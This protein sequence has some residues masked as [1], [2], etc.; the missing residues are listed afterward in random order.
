MAI[1]GT[2]TPGDDN[3][4][5]DASNNLIDALA[6]NDTVNGNGGNDTLIGGLG[7][8]VLLGAVGNDN[9]IG[10]EGNDV[11]GGDN[12]GGTGNDSLSGGAGDD[13]LN[14]GL[15]RDTLVGGAG[16][17]TYAVGS[18]DAIIIEQANQG[19]DIVN[20]SISYTLGANLER[21]TL[22]GTARINGT[23]NALSNSI[24]GNTANNVLSGLAGDDSINGLD[25]N[26]TLTGGIGNDILAGGLGVDR[27]V[28]SGDVNFTLTN[29]RLTGNGTDTLNSIETVFLT[30]GAGNN[31][32]DAS[33]FT[34]N[35]Q[36][37]GGFGDDQLKAGSKGNNLFGGSGNDTLI[38]GAGDD[39]LFGDNQNDLLQGGAG[40]DE[41]K[42]GAG[43]DI[44]NGNEGNDDL[45]GESGNDTINGGTGFDSILFDPTDANF[46]LS[47]KK[48]EVKNASLTETDNLSSIEQAT[49]FGRDS[50]NIMAAS[51]F[52]GMANLFG[53]G[54]N[55]VLTGGSGSDFLA[56][57]DGVDSLNG[58]GDADIKVN[59]ERDT[60]S[61]GSD[62]DFFVLGFNFGFGAIGYSDFGSLDF[63]TITD[64][65]AG[66]GDKFRVGGNS[67]SEYSLVKQSFGGIGSAAIDTQIFRGN[68]LIAVVQDNTDVFIPRD[69]QIFG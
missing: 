36:L 65:S 17:D 46:T 23:G 63:A 41:L 52:S 14:G 2:P 20:S 1:T 53:N 29:T 34:G 26:D 58:F 68:E 64:F 9:L 61:G 31:T 21:L 30:G 12:F 28:E 24:L 54:G 43:N 13:K 55:D 44:L 37:N 33:S 5:G 62:R 27:V 39:G 67:L 51:G 16:S 48:L 3:I 8:D 66:Q 19:N 38:G 42:G 18:A 4:L 60:L 50:G 59:I 15:G 25:G 45:R 35:V 11:L 57:G 69:F 56:G 10:G 47:D 6:G 32:L 7:N 22:V 49:L 40:N